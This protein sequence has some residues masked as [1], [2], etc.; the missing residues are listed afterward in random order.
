MSAMPRNECDDIILH[1]SD[2]VRD[3]SVHLH[4]DDQTMVNIVGNGMKSATIIMLGA[5]GLLN[6]KLHYYKA[7]C[8]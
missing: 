5:L 7:S 4:E 3:A 2:L 8:L 6:N 1:G